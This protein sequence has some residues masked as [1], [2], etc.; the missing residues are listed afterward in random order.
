[1]REFYK[2]CSWGTDNNQANVEKHGISFQ[3]AA[4]ALQDG[5]PIE[6]QR[7]DGSGRYDA[8]AHLNEETI[9]IVYEKSGRDTQIITAHKS[10]DITKQYEE[11]LNKLGVEKNTR[12]NKEFATWKELDAKQK[13]KAKPYVKELE[14]KQKAEKDIVLT[15]KDS[16]KDKEISLKQLETKHRQEAKEERKPRLDNDSKERAGLAKQLEKDQVRSKQQQPS[17]R[18]VS[19]K[20]TR[21]NES[22]RERSKPTDIDRNR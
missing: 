6:T 10:K 9:R 16:P 19:D 22:H 1:M 2:G 15:S 17:R 20:E 4:I 18:D 14:K 21:T 11:Q 13:I 12:F 3:R 7:N 5:R 8:L